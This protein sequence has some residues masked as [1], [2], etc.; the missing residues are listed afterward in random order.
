MSLT[1]YSLTSKWFVHR[2][3]FYFTTAAY[4]MAGFGFVILVRWLYG[5]IRKKRSS[6]GGA[7]RP[8][9]KWFLYGGASLLLMSAATQKSVLQDVRYQRHSAAA[10]A[11]RSYFSTQT[12]VPGSQVLVITDGVQ[13]PHQGNPSHNLGYL[14]FLTK[15]RQ[16]SY[17]II[18]DKNKSGEI[19][20]SEP[21]EIKWGQNM[22]TGFKPQKPVHVLSVNK[23]MVR[24]LRYV[25]A[26]KKTKDAIVWE[27]WAT[28]EGLPA[29]LQTGESKKQFLQQLEH[30]RLKPVDVGFG[31]SL[32]KN[33]EKEL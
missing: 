3:L 1:V 24:E 29:L 8:L 18:A 30:H 16:I 25:V 33:L 26:E 15:S 14:Q 20:S 12:F 5:S 13:F 23:D 21:V 7:G 10:Q 6:R 27:L 22:L 31:R 4:W 17:G 28:T 32:L 11:L 9:L 2:Y 19:F